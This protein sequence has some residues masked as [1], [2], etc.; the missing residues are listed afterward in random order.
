[1]MLKEERKGTVLDP[2]ALG[3]VAARRQADTDAAAKELALHRQEALNAIS[4]DIRKLEQGT[5]DR[6]GA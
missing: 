5:P 4:K 1:M 3:A 2:E 6:G